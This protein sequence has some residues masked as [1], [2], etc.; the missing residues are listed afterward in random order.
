LLAE[1]VRLLFAI[2]SEH[3]V[4]KS[5]R[6]WITASLFIFLI[7]AGVASAQNT[8]LLDAG[9]GG[10]RTGD[11]FSLGTTFTVGST[12][13]FV[14]ALGV[15]DGANGMNG[16]I[17]DGLQSSIPVG[18]FDSSGT[19]LTSITI[20]SGTSATL[21]NGFRYVPITPLD[22]IAGQ[23]YTLAAYYSSSDLDI[24]HDQGGS[25]STSSDF[26]TYLGAFTGSNTVG[27]LSFPTGHTGG[28]AY[29]G[30]NFQ[31]SAVPEP[32]TSLLMLSGFSLLA[33]KRIRRRS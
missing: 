24:L 32:A 10:I 15:W 9:T 23:T 8:L 12:N 17:G 20:P 25:P 26:N 1:L 31:Y 27:S 4:R 7:A 21:F 5:S 11:G 30:P 28:T 18:I 13:E 33:A 3:F 14:L 6:V 19:L 2:M 22:L 29:V 16:S